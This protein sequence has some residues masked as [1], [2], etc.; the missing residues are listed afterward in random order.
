MQPTGRQL[1]LWRKFP[2]CKQVGTPVNGRDKTGIR[3]IL[4]RENERRWC[5]C[6]CIVS[7]GDVELINLLL[8]FSLNSRPDWKSLDQFPG[9]A[10]MRPR[11][12]SEALEGPLALA[13]EWGWP[14]LFPLPRCS[15]VV[16]SR[17]LSIGRER[18]AGRPTFSYSSTSSLRH[19][20]DGLL[21]RSICR[22]F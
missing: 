8:G 10:A 20:A 17:F 22:H 6:R 7:F 14:L 12:L 11:V 13:Q 18:A 1:L 19:H 15:G 4:Y 21:R 2:P 9:L 16:S 3:K 5:A